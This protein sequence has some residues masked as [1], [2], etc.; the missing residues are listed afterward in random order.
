MEAASLQACKRL[1]LE[2]AF[3]A[4]N[5]GLRDEVARL[6]DV[7]PAI[8]VSAPEARQCRA[9]MLW[10]LGRDNE[11]LGCLESCDDPDASMLA[12]VIRA[13]PSFR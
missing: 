11:A 1:L 7:L 9:F 5:Y 6:I 10:G 13:E 8:T 4:V 12:A 3:A 2:G